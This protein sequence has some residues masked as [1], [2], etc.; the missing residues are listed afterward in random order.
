MKRLKTVIIISSVSLLAIYLFMNTPEQEE[1]PMYLNSFSLENLE[2]EI[3]NIDEYKGAPLIINF[4]ATWCS[5]CR[6]EMPLLN[7]IHTDSGINDLKVIGIA[8]DE[9]ELVRDFINELGIDFPILVG[10]GEAYDLMKDLGNSSIT[11]PYTIFV[12]PD[13]LI[14]WSKNTEIKY[15]DLNAMMGVE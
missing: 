10:Q 2:G 5:P 7:T 11:L 3:I 14:S 1:V 8:I 9:P 6:R 4:W 12:E 15:E 13:G